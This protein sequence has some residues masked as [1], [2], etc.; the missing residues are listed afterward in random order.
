MRHPLRDLL[1]IIR[2]EDPSVVVECGGTTNNKRIFA[3]MGLGGW[4]N[5]ERDDLENVAKR[6]SGVVV[7]WWCER[8][9]PGSWVQRHFFLCAFWFAQAHSHSQQKHKSRYCSDSIK[10]TTQNKEIF[11]SCVGVGEGLHIIG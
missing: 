3:M 11:T 8:E 9:S 2:F 1:E 5:G 4:I 6:C 7:V 10:T